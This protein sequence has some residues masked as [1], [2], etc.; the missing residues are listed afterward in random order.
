MKK[1]SYLF[2]LF[3]LLS[4]FTCDDEALEGDFVSDNANSDT[5]LIGQWST[6]T[7]EADISTSTEFAG[8][9]FETEI[10]V[11]GENFDYIVTFSETGYTTNGSYDLTSTT[12]INGE[13]SLPLTDSYSN[14]SGQGTYTIQGNTMLIDGSFFEVD[15][16]DVQGGEQSANYSISADG[17][18]LTITQDEEIID[19]S[20]GASVIS[21]VI[22]TSTY[23][24]I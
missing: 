23:Q 4:A 1:L 21:H 16:M 7:F 24:K 6:L 17:Q 9:S 13:A 8:Q 10:L 18:I 11:E 2:C 14:V 5:E 12:S 19:N 22:S 20:N 15:G 3:I